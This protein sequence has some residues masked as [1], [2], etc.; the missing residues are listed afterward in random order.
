VER[1]INTSERDGGETTL[2]LQR[3]GLSK[4]LLSA[5]ADD[6][7]KVSLGLL[8]VASHLLD[9]N[10]LEL[11]EVGD[12]GEGVQGT[13]VTGT[14]VL[15]VGDVVVDNLQE[16]ASLLGNVVDDELESRLVEG[17]A[18]TAGVDSAHGVV[19]S[20]SG[21]TLDGNLGMPFLHD[22]VVTIDLAAGRMWIA[23]QR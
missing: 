17:L 18:D 5:S 22:K 23:Y 1:H 20:T 19:G 13:E 12:T 10:L 3:L 14:H 6:L 11:D 2:K 15:H 4:G 7:A 21:I 8:N 16:P 9:I